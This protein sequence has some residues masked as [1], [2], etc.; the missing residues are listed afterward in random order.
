MEITEQVIHILETVA[1]EVQAR[2]T[3][4]SDLAHGFEHVHRVYHL[5]MSLSEQEHADSLIVGMAALLHDLGRTTRGPTRSHAERSAKLAAELLAPYDLPPETQYAIRHA[6]LAH[7]YRHGIEPSTLEARVLYDADRLDSLGACGVMRW[8]MTATHGR[9][10]QTGTY[11][12]DDPFAL[13]RVPDGQRYLLD[14]FF[15]KLLQLTEAMTTATGRALAERRIAFL[16]LFLQELQHELAEGGYGYDM[17]E[18]VTYRLLW[19]EKRAEEQQ[20]KPAEE[21]QRGRVV[22]IHRIYDVQRAV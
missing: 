17:P 9:W 22:A 13:W 20:K 21:I 5:A 10:P 15:T 2:F 14:C 3:D 8:A 1:T 4:F 16:R 19:G 11:H 6:I 18:E 7:G 12:P